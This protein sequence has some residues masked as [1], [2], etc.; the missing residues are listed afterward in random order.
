[1]GPAADAA[2]RF[3]RVRHPSGLSDINDNFSA[4]V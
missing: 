1:M 2:D 3:N 4:S